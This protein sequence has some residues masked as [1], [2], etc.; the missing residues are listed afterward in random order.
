[1][2]SRI[3]IDGGKVLE[4]SPG[5][6][7][8]EI[9]REG[10]VKTEAPCG[11]KGI[12]GKCRVTLKG[13]GGPVTDE[14]R[15]FLSS[16]DIA[17]GV[18][19]S[20]LC[21]PVG[22]VAVSL[23]DQEEKG[24]AIL[25]DGNRPDFRICPAIGA[26]PISIPRPEIRDGMSLLDH[27]ESVAGPLKPD[28]SLVRRIP[29]AF[30]SKE[31]TAV[32]HKDSLI[33]LI[34]ERDPE[35]YGLAVDVGTTTVVVSLISLKTGETVG[36][37]SEI[38]PQK[39]F[40]LD[41]IS[42]IER[43]ETF[44]TGLED[45]HDAIISC[46][47]RLVDKVCFDKGTS[48]KRIYE[49]AIGSNATMTSLLLGVHP[50]SLGRAP[51]SPVL[52]RGM[53]VPSVDLGV[54]LAPGAR[55]YVLPGVSAYIGS[56]IVA[57]MVATELME[58]RGIRLFIDI[59]TNGEIV[60]SDRGR[61]SACSCAAG[62]ALE[63]MNI[64]CGMR[65]SDGAVESVRLNESFAELG[66]IGGGTPR[67]LCGSAILD[68]LSEVVRLEMV[69]KTGRLKPGPMIAEENGKRALVLRERDPRLTVTQG[70]L[71]Q[72]QLAR[73][74]ILSGFISLLEAND[75]TMAD[76][77]QVLVAGQF[78][79]HLSVD[80]LTGSGLIPME[81]KDRI[82]YCGNTSGAGAAMC[83]LSRKARDDAEMLSDMVDYVELS[84]LESYDRLFSRCL[85]FE[86][87]R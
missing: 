81:L 50:W 28:A 18:R 65:A 3:T 31:V 14:E 46:L 62:P 6:T 32:F 42:R 17:E 36:S 53:T 10:G 84:V 43:C 58:D 27:L 83:L 67:G 48:R 20:C 26:V 13:D 63:G 23:S 51:F 86:V 54:E 7:L 68:V 70:D 8:L 38:N 15:A 61:L 78:G 35:L 37:A 56:D 4:F 64:S 75:L 60:L 79:R 72:V 82:T 34:P 71:R 80:S 1:M 57:G 85:Q 87:S 77:D 29:Q 39:D 76:I 9:L 25:T 66:V 21:R 44:P 45:L 19:L 41:V 73:G 11:G 16:E 55:A 69:G 49:M 22:D 12:C 47:D 30:R 59:G 40:G 33:D 2:T 24:S 5:P 74:A 52:R